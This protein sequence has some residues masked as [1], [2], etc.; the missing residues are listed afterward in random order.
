MPLTLVLA[1]LDA[2][3]PWGPGAST[4]SCPRQ[5][6][7]LPLLEK[8]FVHSSQEKEAEGRW[9]KGM[10]PRTSEDLGFREPYPLL[11]AP[12][13]L[14]GCSRVTG[15]GVDT[16][17]L[18]DPS[19]GAAGRTWSRSEHPASARGSLPGLGTAARLREQRRAH[20]MGWR[21]SSARLLPFFFFVILCLCKK[22]NFF[23][24]KSVGTKQHP[25]PYSTKSHIRVRVSITPQI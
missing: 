16:S 12:A 9:A 4:P 2:G 6:L 23:A 25:T 24:R 15:P 20:P 11:L 22:N 18:R 17:S 10:R 3:L 7:R 5:H 19:T 1:L 14:C 21:A 13:E 8:T